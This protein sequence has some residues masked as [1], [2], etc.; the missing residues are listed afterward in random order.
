LGAIFWRLGKQRVAF[1]LLAVGGQVLGKI[2]DAADLPRGEFEG[3]AEMRFAVLK[4]LRL[5]AIWARA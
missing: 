5:S 4:S 1:L 3:A 2:Y